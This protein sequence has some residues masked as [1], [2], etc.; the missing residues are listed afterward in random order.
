MCGREGPSSSSDGQQVY[1]E[2]DA[3]FCD[4]FRICLNHYLKH[5]EASGCALE[6]KAAPRFS[7]FRGLRHAQPCPNRRT[8]LSIHVKRW[9]M[10]HKNLR[11]RWTACNSTEIPVPPEKQRP[12]SPTT[13]GENR[14]SQQRS[15]HLRARPLQSAGPAPRRVRSET[16]CHVPWKKMKD[17]L[18]MLAAAQGSPMSARRRRFREA[19]HSPPRRATSSANA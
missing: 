15:R 17:P 19:G 8:A 11:P 9:V 10:I 14:N 6:I 13:R 16:Y 3:G 4:N 1:L 18:P 12:S 5:G 2:I 7:S